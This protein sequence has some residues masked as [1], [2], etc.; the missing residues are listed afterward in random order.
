MGIAHRVLK[1]DNCVVD[2]H[3]LLKV[4]DFGCSV[5]IKYP[6]ETKIHKSKGVCGSDPYIAP[7]QY[8]QPDYDATLTDIWSCGIIYVCMIIRRFPWRIPRASQDQS[9]KNFIT[10]STQGAARL[11]KM[12]PRESRPILSKILEPDPTKRATLQQV[13]D[14]PWVRNID[15]CTMDYASDHHC[16]HLLVKPS[17]SILEKRQNIVMLDS[18]PSSSSSSTPDDDPYD[19]KKKKK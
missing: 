14:D 9:Y 15:M 7:E 16:H 18:P 3:G 1:L 2:D 8:T 6:H 17:P 10:P 11:F 4:I 5:V 13:L 19:G 12:L